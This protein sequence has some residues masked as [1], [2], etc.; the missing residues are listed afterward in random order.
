[1]QGRR[2]RLLVVLARTADPCEHDGMYVALLDACALWPSRQRDFLLS[3]AVAN[4][5][6]PVWSDV[7]LEELEFH[8]AA[9]LRD[10]GEAAQLAAKR[11]AQLIQRMRQALM[12]SRRPD[13]SQRL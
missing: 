7:T 9:K 13:R 3:L 11:A 10:R 2:W 1:V 5:F 12:T 6:A 4:V 8:E